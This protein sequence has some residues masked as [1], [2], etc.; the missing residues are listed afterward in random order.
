MGQIDHHLDEP[1]STDSMQEPD[2]LATLVGDLRVPLTVVLGRSQLLQR[3][4][5]TGRITNAY[6]CMETLVLVDEAV[7]ALNA[8]LQRLEHE[9][10]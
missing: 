5:R 1:E 10:S 4:I 6:A 2:A 9:R 7:R 3:R 8:R